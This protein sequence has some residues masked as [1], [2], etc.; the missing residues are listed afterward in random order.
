MQRLIFLLASGE[1]G[2]LEPALR[3]REERLA[4]VARAAGA[5]LRLAVQLEGDPLAAE[6]GGDGVRTIRPLHGVVDLTVPGEDPAP[7]LDAVADVAS[8]IGDAV[9]WS[10][11][12]V[13]IGT[14]HEVLPTAS[15]TLLLTLA[16]NRL[17]AIDRAGFHDYWLNS[18]AALALSLLDDAAKG[19]MGYQQVHADEAAS[20]KA[21]AL[22]G[23]AASTFDG[24]LQVCL[25]QIMDL[26]HL[27]VPGF[28][29]AIMKDEEHFADQSAEMFGAFTRTLPSTESSRSTGG[30]T[31]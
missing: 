6:A 17:P 11:S 12:S 13:A 28:A 3:D 5:S 16:A 9:D 31:S 29:E 4:T 1:P 7:L 23:A 21:T 27:T 20:A 19:R 24:V 18:H 25:A 8:I 15:D 2:S 14:V 10:A 30:A 22:A 26:P